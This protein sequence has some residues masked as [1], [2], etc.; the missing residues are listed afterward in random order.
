MCG[1]GGGAGGNWG[2]GWDEGNV[3]IIIAFVY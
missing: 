2:R 3:I 1:G